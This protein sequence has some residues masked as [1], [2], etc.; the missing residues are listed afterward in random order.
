MIEHN[1]IFLSLY[2]ILSVNI[3]MIEST[4]KVSPSYY[5]C[6]TFS[7]PFYNTVNILKTY[8]QQE[9]KFSDNERTV[10]TSPV[11]NYNDTKG[12]HKVFDKFD[13]KIEDIKCTCTLIVKTKLV[14]LSN[15][16]EGLQRGGPIDVA[17]DELKVLKEEAGFMVLL[18][19]K[20]KVKAG[21]WFWSFFLKILAIIEYESN[22]SFFE[23]TTFDQAELQSGITNFIQYCKNNKYLPNNIAEY[24]LM[25]NNLNVPNNIFQELRASRIIALDYVNIMQYISIDYLYLKP[26]WDEHELLFGEIT[27]S[28]V[29]WRPTIRRHAVEVNKTK[30][31]INNRQWISQPFGHLSYHMLIK[32]II[33]VR[34]YI[35]LWVML[36]I[37]NKEMSKMGQFQQNILFAEAMDTIYMV[38]RFMLYTETFFFDVVA[39][40][41]SAINEHHNNFDSVIARLPVRVKE[42]LVELNGCTS[43]GRD[44]ISVDI[45]EEF[46]DGMIMSFLQEFGKNFN[47]LK[48]KLTILNYDLALSI[49]VEGN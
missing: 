16:L 25:S 47:L 19:Q 12:R 6:Q 33:S 49:L 28:D 3:V 2:F 20:G 7:Y 4:N 44:W 23:G 41:R 34:M 22:S 35:F 45:N 46:T 11:Q 17:R 31:Y 38:Q 18:F 21:K 39:E 15:I 24:D 1:C 29:E 37:F 48:E 40:V 5:V 14:Y 42:I 43:N 27:G 32:Q 26:L 13:K 36:V 8:S 9:I 10:L 30:E